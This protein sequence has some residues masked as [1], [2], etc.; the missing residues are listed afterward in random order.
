MGSK[1]LVV[2]PKQN[3]LV[4]QQVIP[5]EKTE[6]IL[7]LARKQYELQKEISELTSVLDLKQKE[8]NN[9]RQKLLPDAMIAAGIRTLVTSTGYTILVED[10]IGAHI[11]EENK[12]AAFAWL[13][14]NGHDSII[15]NTVLCAFSKGEDKA[16]LRLKQVL[17]KNKFSFTEKE[18]IHHQTLQAFVRESLK[19][20]KKLPE[21]I[22]Y[23]TI[24]TSKIKEPKNGTE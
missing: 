12:P 1:K 17:K 19:L 15:K 23:E 14:K 24:P 8:H 7:V 2:I 6:R 18:D 13:R 10:F 11:K 5:A 4:S 9:I 22:S 3:E 16:A 20:G 21:S